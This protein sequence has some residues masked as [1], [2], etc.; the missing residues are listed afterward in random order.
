MLN[1]MRNLLTITSFV[2]VSILAACG[3]DLNRPS[4]QETIS[5]PATTPST[6][7]ERP[8]SSTTGLLEAT[9]TTRAE[10]PSTIATRTAITVPLQGPTAECSN[11]IDLR[12]SRSP[13]TILAGV[14]GDSILQI[15]GGFEEVAIL[16]KCGED[17]LVTTGSWTFQAFELGESYLAP[18]EANERMR[19]RWFEDPLLLEE[20]GWL[21][22]FAEIEEVLPS[23]APM[24][25]T[26]GQT[27]GY[28]GNSCG[29]PSLAYG[30]FATD[31]FGVQEPWAVDGLHLAATWREGGFIAND[32][33][34]FAI[35]EPLCTDDGSWSRLVLGTFDIETGDL[36]EFR[37]LW[38]FERWSTASSVNHRGP[39]TLALDDDGAILIGGGED[40]ADMLHVD[41]LCASAR[42][43]RPGGG[44]WALFEAGGLRRQLH[45][46]MDGQ[47]LSSVVVDTEGSVFWAADVNGDGVEQVFVGST[48]VMAGGA[49]AWTLVGD[50]IA[51]LM[52]EG[53][54]LRLWNGS[55]GGEYGQFGCI[56]SEF[57]QLVAP[58]GGETVTVRLTLYAVEGTS[59]RITSTESVEVLRASYFSDADPFIPETPLPLESQIRSCR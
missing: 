5:A 47:L 22:A 18:P 20:P 52:L 33:G 4:S 6:Q 17:L 30:I 46:C 9:T 11:S 27:H 51:P 32:K 39:T 28:V 40:P 23:A 42:P 58:S 45:H 53:S 57:A 29:E 31:E 34:D 56:G 3:E 25:L 2:I 10:S 49:T 50:A 48:S 14:P 36:L 12:W 19:F 21:P 7:T 15:A 59:A 8:R 26:I 37:R 35:I 41:E 16:T 44:D 43:L 13:D 38:G 1:G 54:Q 24:T 55:F